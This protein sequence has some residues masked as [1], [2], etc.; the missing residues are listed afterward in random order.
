MAL[1]LSSKPSP[2]VR[3]AATGG[4]FDSLKRYPVFR[5]L[6]LGMFA[7]SVSQWMQ[8][9]ALGWI[10]LTMTNSTS[11]VGLVTFMGGLP[12][13][14]V[15]P[16][17][18]T[19]IDRLDRRRVMLVCQALAAIL[20]VIVAAD[21]ISGYVHPAH[22]VVAAFLN[23]SL[24]AM[25]GPTQQAIV[26]MLVERKDLTNAVGLM[27]A[28]Q[29]TTRIAGPPVAGVVIGLFGVGAA[30][31]LQA[32]ALGVAFVF[33]LGVVLPRRS[34][35]S[36]VRGGVFDGMQLIARRPDL[37]ALFLQACLPSLLIFPYIS[38]LNVYAKDILQIGPT[39]LGLLMAVSGAGA[40]TG[41]LMT[42]S[43]GWG[44]GAGRI[45]IVGTIVYGAMIMA[46]ALVGDLRPMLPLMFL[47]SMT[48]SF[49]MSGNT[50]LLQHRITDDI[51]GRVMGTYMLTWGLMPAG[52]LPMGLL[53]AQV[54]TPWAIASL[55]LL[56]SVL[57]A[58][59]AAT[60]PALRN[61]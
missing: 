43:R 33:V 4:T 18:G 41:A 15:G 17:G 2:G 54:G 19:L 37:R 53:A 9:I 29:N 48:A 34:D 42:A 56:C 60:S 47:A 25:L 45:L 16:V 8:Q 3:S 31:L 21:V 40:V 26:P 61:L 59:L 11:F 13:F 27:S 35:V 46:V 1:R 5:R 32:V 12:F 14:V 50:A 22:L 24:Q 23:G 36:T 7:G 30:F 28:G 57:T 58:V 49:F 6:W 20:A 10:A 38:F 52:A 44:P 39:G 55:A 51:R